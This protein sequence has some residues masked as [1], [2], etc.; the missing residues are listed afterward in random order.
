ME[1]LVKNGTR[2]PKIGLY[3]IRPPPSSTATILKKRWMMR[4]ANQP[5]SELES[6]TSISA[7]GLWVCTLVA[8]GRFRQGDKKAS[9][10][11]AEVFAWAVAIT[12]IWLAGFLKQ[13]DLELKR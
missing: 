1:P 11:P 4:V 10:L 13:C 2:M 3:E 8:L 12:P 5:R 7:H 9:R 6:S